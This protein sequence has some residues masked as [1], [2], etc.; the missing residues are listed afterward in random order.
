VERLSHEDQ[1][2]IARRA[3]LKAGGS[4]IRVRALCL[5]PLLAIVVGLLVAAAARS[6][7]AQSQADEYHV[8]AAFLFHFVQLVEWPAGAPGGETSPVNL[9]LLGQGP[10]HGELEAT[11]A[12]KSLGARPLRVVHLK[13]EEDFQACQ[14]LF[15]SRHDAARLDHLVTALKDAPVLTVGES[16]G[17]AEQGGM[18][19]LLLVDNK[20]RFEINL[21]AAEQAKLK[22]SSRL[23]LLAKVVIGNHG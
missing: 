7:R 2:G 13:P 11:L 3:R 17:F 1:I 22:I 6:A 16:D 21:Q 10:F 14:V 5:L 4:E 20:V 19:G 18:I 15:V 12:G 8:K 9:C 23:L